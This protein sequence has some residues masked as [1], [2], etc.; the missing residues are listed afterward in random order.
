MKKHYSHSTSGFTFLLLLDWL[1]P[2]P[3]EYLYTSVSHQSW[4]DQKSQVSGVHQN[5][6]FVYYSEHCSLNWH[7]RL[8]CQNIKKIETSNDGYSELRENWLKLKLTASAHNPIC[9]HDIHSTRPP[10]VAVL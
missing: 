1:V 4:L 3:E 9:K 6:T 5:V 10:S 7:N 8:M 2:Y